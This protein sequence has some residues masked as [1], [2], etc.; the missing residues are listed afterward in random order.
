MSWFRTVRNVVLDVGTQRLA[1]RLE[2]MKTS[3]REFKEAFAAYRQTLTA[4]DT[5]QQRKAEEVEK[6]LVQLLSQQDEVLQ[7]ASSGRVLE[8]LAT[9]KDLN[10]DAGV[11]RVRVIENQLETLIRELESHKLAA[12][13]QFSEQ[14]TVSYVDFRRF[15]LI[16]LSVAVL[17]ALVLGSLTTLVISDQLGG[18]PGYAAEMVRRVASGDLSV[19]VET[20]GHDRSSLLFALKEMV[21]GLS[22]TIAQVQLGAVTL[23]SAAEQVASSSASLSHGTSEQAAAAEETTT[24]L[25]QMRTSIQ[26]NAERSQVMAQ[27]AAKAAREADEGGQAVTQAVQAMTDIVAKVGIIGEIAYQTNLLSLNAATGPAGVRV[28]HRA[29]SLRGAG[30]RGDEPDERHH[31]AECGSLGAARRDR[32][33]ARHAGPVTPADHRLVP[34]AHHVRRTQPPEAAFRERRPVPSPQD[35]CTG[36]SIRAASIRSRVGNLSHPIG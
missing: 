14:A 33:R 9:S 22:E 11:K 32:R 18:E 8:L 25:G 21:R 30:V 26:Q 19:N 15:V 23:N 24:N 13:Q 12:M 34:A 4:A 5:V 35:G 16:C 27:M 6:L 31:P 36:T 20:K 7:L 1:E 2:E 17:I 29:I 28:L 10:L 3:R